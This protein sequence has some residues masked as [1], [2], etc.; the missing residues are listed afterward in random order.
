MKLLFKSIAAGIIG[1]LALGATAAFAEHNRDYRPEICTI[2]HDHRSHDANYY[3]YYSPDKYYRAGPYRGPRLN[4]TVRFGDRYDRG[5]NHTYRGRNGY[6]RGRDRNYRGGH[7][8]GVNRQVFDTRYRARIILTEA[9][10]RGRHGPRLVCTVKARG[11]EAQY[12]STRRMYRVANNNCSPR[13][14]VQVYS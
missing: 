11:P 1:L 5:R 14:R 2:D 10:E 4:V 7:R 12:V 9:V 3:D 6:D 8:R 13:A